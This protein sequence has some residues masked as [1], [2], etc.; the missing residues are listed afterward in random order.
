MID[1]FLKIE[2]KKQISKTI[3]IAVSF[4]LLQVRHILP[5]VFSVPFPSG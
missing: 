2:A 4:P 1:L 5:S 3:E